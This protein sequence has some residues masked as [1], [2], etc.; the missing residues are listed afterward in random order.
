MTTYVMASDGTQVPV[1]DLPANFS[2]TGTNLTQISYPYQNRT[3]V[4]NF[5][6]TGTMCTFISDLLAMGFEGWAIDRQGQ[7]LNPDG[8]LFLM[9]GR[10]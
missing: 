5:L 7:R 3:F 8:S 9:G 4:Y 10:S 1:S 6:Y 2:Y